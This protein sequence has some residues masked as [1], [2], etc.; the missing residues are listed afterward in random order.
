[1]TKQKA[2]KPRAHI[3]FESELWNAANELRGAVAENEYKNHVLS[4]LF[5]KHLS[6]RCEIRREE[7]K[8]N[9]P[10]LILNIFTH[11]KVVQL[12]FLDDELEYKIKNVYKPPEEAICT[13][14]RNVQS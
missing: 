13:Y 2:T 7:I 10:I 3:D 14:L 8:K 1:M 5:V 6:E 4:L 11:D 12:S 9:S